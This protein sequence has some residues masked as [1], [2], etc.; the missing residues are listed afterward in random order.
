MST[1]LSSISEFFAA[2]FGRAARPYP[3]LSA[4]RGLDAPVNDAAA[5]GVSIEEAK[6][7]SGQ[8]YWKV[9]R[10]HHLTADE[11]NFRQHIFV[12]MQDEAG[13]RLQGGAV[14]VSWPG[15][16]QIVA[17]DKPPG[18]PAGNFP[19][20]KYQVC[21]VTAIGIPGETLVSDKVTGLHTGHKDEGPGNRLFH[22]SFAL[23]FQRTVAGAA[24]P[25]R[26]SVISGRVSNGAGRTVLLLQ[27]GAS[28]A[29][30]VVAADES[31]SLTALAAGTYQVAVQ[32]ADVRSD[33]VTVDG[34]G[35]ATVNLTLPAA[36]KEESMVSGRVLRGAGKTIELYAS[37][38]LVHWTLVAADE[39]YQFTG[40]PAGLY[41]VGIAGKDVVSEDFHLDGVN[42]RQQDL[43]IPESAGPASKPL[44][45][46]VLFAPLNTVQ[47]QIDWLLAAPYLQ[48]FG[49]TAGANLDHAKLA[50]QVTMI[51]GGPDAPGAAVEQALAAAGCRVERIAG[52][53][54][55]VATELAQ[56]IEAGQP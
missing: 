41:R 13:N 15:G 25:A 18:E 56:R 23:V 34:R 53:A 16:D 45:R 10:V 46:Y 7:T 6:P 11:N 54:N 8:L 43:E 55:A 44:T 9:Q 4:S 1:L 28:V 49:L 52:D 48:A 29:Q 30:T 47:G 42:A 22:H 19:M 33:P 35:A 12:D 14:R 36:P 51:G 2:L 50:A 32:G 3:G 27:E 40:L 17:L 39:A 21:E 31:Y 26:E 24:A 38:A 5:Y 37:G 20:W